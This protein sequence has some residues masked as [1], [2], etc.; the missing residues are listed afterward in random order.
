MVGF[1]CLSLLDMRLTSDRVQIQPHSERDGAFY[2]EV[3]MNSG[4][5]YFLNDQYFND[6]SDPYL[7][8][9]KEKV[10][11][12]VH[13]RPCFYAFEDNSHEGLFWL[14]P[15]SSQTNKFKKYTTLKLRNI[16]SVIL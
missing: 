2:S 14:V 16:A 1:K 7:M 11:G 13:N 15:F 4:H 5:F 3:H 8:Q 9:N 6:F 12:Q 10:N